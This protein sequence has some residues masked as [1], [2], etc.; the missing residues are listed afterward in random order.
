MLNAVPNLPLKDR[1]ADILRQEIAAGRLADGQE[2]TQEGLSEALSVSRIPLREAFLQLEA[3][4]LLQRLPNR[5]VRVVGISPQRLRQNFRVL[6]SVEGELALLALEA[7][8]EDR[9]LASLAALEAAD[10]WEAA[11]RCDETLHLSFA[12]ALD[13]PGLQQ[14]HR[15]QRRGFFLGLF[16]LL[17][18]DEP[19]LL[20]LN[21]AIC[22]PLAEGDA[23]GLR[24][25]IADYYEAFRRAVEALP[26]AN[27]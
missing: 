5:H 3:E 4:G 26:L 25:A 11:V 12:A 1:I 24:C 14:L 21:Q 18:P 2:L 6:A 17:P 27:P 13:N 22:R 23:R 16:Q 7:G 19:R 8:G 9:T 15:T 10:S 20:R